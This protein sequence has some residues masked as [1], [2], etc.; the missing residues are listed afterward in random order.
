MILH[1]RTH[2]FRAEYLEEG[3]RLAC[4]LNRLAAEKMGK[5]GMVYHPA[6]LGSGLSRRHV[7]VDTYHE[8]LTAMDAYYSA[9]LAM[10]EVKALLPRWAEVEEE[11]WAEN[12]VILAD[13]RERAP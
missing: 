1:R 12:F 4:E 8:S 10:A 13:A 7:I 6:M 5:L 11:S 2:K 3:I 9:F